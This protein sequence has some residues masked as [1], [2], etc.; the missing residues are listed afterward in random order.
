[1]ISSCVSRARGIVDL[2]DNYG[3]PFLGEAFADAA[4]DP[5]PTTGNDRDL[6]RE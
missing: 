2:G 3:R 4:P 5:A 1:V 6:A